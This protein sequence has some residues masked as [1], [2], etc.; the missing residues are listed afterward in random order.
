MSSSSGPEEVVLLGLHLSRHHLQ[1]LL[2]H[3]SLKYSLG[4]SGVLLLE[5][6]ELALD[7]VAGLV[8]VGG[9]HGE[10]AAV[11]AE[12]LHQSPDLLFGPVGN[13][14]LGLEYGFVFVPVEFVLEGEFVDEGGE[15]ADG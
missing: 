5:H 14:L 10:V 3:L 11:F 4:Q 12:Q 15:G 1:G 13:V 2:G 9:Y 7:L 6:L 8:Q